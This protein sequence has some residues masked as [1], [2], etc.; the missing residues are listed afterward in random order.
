LASSNH[1]Q[2]ILAALDTLPPL[3][4]VAQ[5]LISLMNDD[6]SSARD[7]DKLISNDQALTAR[8]LK[9]A[10][11]SAY[12]KSRDIFRITEAVVL[13]GH[14]TITNIVL[15]VT[16]EDVVIGEHQREFAAKAWEHSLTCAALAEGL[17]QITGAAEPEHAYVAGLLHDIGLLVQDRAVPDV[18]HSIIA[19][20][21][22]D[23]LAMERR[24]MGLNHAQIGLKLLDRWLLPPPLCEAVRFHHAPHHKYQRTNPLV[25]IIALADRL[26][27]IAG[28]VIY[29]QIA[30]QDVFR[31]IRDIGLKDEQFSQIFATL[32]KSHALTRGLREDARIASSS[33]DTATEKPETDSPIVIFAA[34][35]RR[36]NWYTAVLRFLGQEVIAWDKVLDGSAPQSELEHVLIDFHGATPENRQVL[37]RVVDQLALAP[38]VVGDIRHTPPEARWQNAP[39]LD[40][41]FRETDIIQAKAQS[42]KEVA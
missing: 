9:I 17:A 37:N 30:K 14:S 16:V 28:A 21:P 38:I 40:E 24:E 8:I 13:L 29:P 39:H 27:A 2:A 35:S 11:S 31:L 12:G 34:D 7:L 18:L 23:P 36:Q 3:N 20:Q 6:R 42:Q 41:I 4:E 25:N 10:N 33:A 1:R 15:S 19:R 5:K 26:S 32:H 22:V